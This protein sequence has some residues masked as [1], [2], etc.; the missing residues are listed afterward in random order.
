MSR[1]AVVAGNW[2]MFKT[3]A[4]AMAL[5]QDIVKALGRLRRVDVILCPPSRVS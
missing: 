4:E 5:I 2:K 3:Q 1:R